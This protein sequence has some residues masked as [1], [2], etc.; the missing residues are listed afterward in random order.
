LIDHGAVFGVEYEYTFVAVVHL[1]IF[2]EEKI[3]FAH[4]L[5]TAVAAPVLRL[6]YIH[7]YL[8]ASRTYLLWARTADILIR[9]AAVP[10]IIK[11]VCSA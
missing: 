3:T 1:A 9:V 7:S 6:R 4:L 11:G 8:A 2:L 5:L 10:P